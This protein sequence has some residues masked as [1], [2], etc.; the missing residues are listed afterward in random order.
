M[1]LTSGRRL[2]LPFVLRGQRRFAVPLN[3]SVRQTTL[4]DVL[5]GNARELAAQPLPAGLDGHLLCGVVDQGWRTHSVLDDRVMYV[6]KRDAWHYLAWPGSYEAYLE[7][8]FSAKTRESFARD[9]ARFAEAFGENGG[10]LGIQ[11]FRTPAEVE[12]FVRHAAIVSPGYAPGSELRDAAAEGRLHG[13]V[14]FAKGAPVAFVCLRA[15]GDTLQYTGGG[16]RDD[17]RQ[18]SAGTILHLA[19]LRLLF[20]DGCFRLLDFRPGESEVKRQF[21][22][23]SLR[24]ATVLQLKRTLFHR[25]LLGAHA[26]L[27]RRDEDNTAT[28]AVSEEIQTLL[29]E[30]A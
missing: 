21:A 22:N 26:L 19:A 9:E 1:D 14:L 23:G 28:E 7:G 5:A 4:V 30:R 10:R 13:L 12:A 15:V 2:S 11:D 8:R 25:L 24:A 27:Q 6:V 20:A 29:G 17:F 18:W 16:E 3:L